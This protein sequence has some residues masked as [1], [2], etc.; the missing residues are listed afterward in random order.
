MVGH[1]VNC[2]QFLTAFGND[3]SDIFL[4][5]IIMIMPDEVLPAFNSEDYMNINLRVGI[6]H[7][8]KMRPATKLGNLFVRIGRAYGAW[9]ILNWDLSTERPALRAFLLGGANAFEAQSDG[10]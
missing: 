4:Q 8:Q 3:A 2:Y 7:I 1:I 5:F 9:N 10:R 6:G